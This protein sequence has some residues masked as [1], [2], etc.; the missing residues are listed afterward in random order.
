M[1]CESRIYVVKKENFIDEWVGLRYAQKIA[2][3]NMSV[4]PCL[5]S[6]F[7]KQTDCYIY[8]DDGDTAITKDKYG[9]PLTEAPLSDVI[10]FLEDEVQRGETY[11]RIKPLLALLKNFDMEQWRNLV[12]LHYG[13]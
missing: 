1:G 11:R 13:Y 7:K 6:V 10:E 12:C 3:V 5:S 2:C 4:F 9:N 8:A